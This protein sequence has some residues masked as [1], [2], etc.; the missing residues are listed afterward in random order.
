MAAF[1]IEKIIESI[2]LL[3]WDNCIWQVWDS[4]VCALQ[5]LNVEELKRQSIAAEKFIPVLE[6]L[7]S[8]EYL[9]LLWSKVLRED[10]EQSVDA[11]TRIINGY[12]LISNVYQ[13]NIPDFLLHQNYAILVLRALANALDHTPSI[14]WKTADAVLNDLNDKNT[15]IF[16]VQLL[17]LDCSESTV[18]ALCAAGHMNPMWLIHGAS[19]IIKQLFRSN[20]R[21][22]LKLES[23]LRDF[24]R[25][26]SEGGVRGSE[27]IDSLVLIQYSNKQPPR[28]VC[29]VISQIIMES[30]PS[31]FMA[32]VLDTTMFVWGDKTFVSKAAVHRMTLLTEVIIATLAY[33]D[34]RQLSVVG[35]RG[36][37]LELVLSMGI[38]NYLEVD[39]IGIRVQ[40]MRV[41]QAYAR[42]IG[43]PLHFTELD[44]IDAEEARENELAAA[45]APSSSSGVS[46]EKRPGAIAPGK[47]TSASGSSSAPSNNTESTNVGYDTDSSEEMMG[48]NV[49]END[50]LGGVYNYKDKLLTTNYLRDCLQSKPFCCLFCLMHTV[51]IVTETL[52]SLD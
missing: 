34:R 14:N 13:H 36:L 52:C 31:S 51:Q 40:G 37:P 11:G 8:S 26:A 38:S 6:K 20:S 12:R 35:S 21:N 45:Q 18:N 49:D 47:P 3:D 27:L 17:S 32:E 46:R 44:A 28:R 23:A 29:T 4:V 9:H 10:D 5:E 39:N 19:A 7:I 41:A 48:Y 43:E 1:D 16:L 24:V 33:C 15:D 30:I 42:V 22:R 2:D 25:A 50:H